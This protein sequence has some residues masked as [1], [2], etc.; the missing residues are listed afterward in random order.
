MWKKSSFL[1]SV[2]ENQTPSNSNF[3]QKQNCKSIPWNREEN[4]SQAEYII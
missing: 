3:I 1:F 4:I 2:S